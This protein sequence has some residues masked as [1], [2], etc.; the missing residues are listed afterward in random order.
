MIRYTPLL[1][2]SALSAPTCEQPGDKNVEN[3]MSW[4]SCPLD[5]NAWYGLSLGS[6]FDRNYAI[7]SCNSFE[8]GEL[9]SI[10]NEDMDQCAFYSMRLMGDKIKTSVWQ[11]LFYASQQDKY[12]YCVNGT[13]VL[14]GECYGDNVEY[15]NW[16]SD[17]ANTGNDCATSRLSGA[18]FT[19]DYSWEKENCAA[20]H[21]FMCRVDCDS[22]TP[23]TTTK[24][25]PTTTVCSKMLGRLPH[26]FH[27]WRFSK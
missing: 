21:Q 20:R 15:T 23:E 11:S 27:L 13:D 18:G 26:F 10:R 1:A 22:T 5:D 7:Q 24:T 2:V 9:I 16:K 4:Y 12:L 8:G 19:D 3:G 14:M 17:E 6:T 25:S